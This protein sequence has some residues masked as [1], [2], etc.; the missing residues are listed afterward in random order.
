M[1]DASPTTLICPDLAVGWQSCQDL[2][3][4]ISPIAESADMTRTWN[5]V[6]VNLAAPEFQLYAV[7]LTSGAA[8]LRSPA[9]SRLWPGSAFQL[10]PPSEFGDFIADGNDSC[11]LL[12]DPYPGSVRCLT[13]GFDDVAF[14]VLDRV[15]TLDAPASGLVRVY[16][17]PVLY[18][19][20]WAP[21]SETFRE[22]DAEVS[23]SLET[24]EY[25]APLFFG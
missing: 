24:Q 12:R 21:W 16:Y 13:A 9:L 8:E 10:V 1:F 20:V 14:S 22:R 11:T 17:R 4:E 19:M 6:G 18:L 2:S 15:V 25:G 3:V 23:W 7:R 5:G